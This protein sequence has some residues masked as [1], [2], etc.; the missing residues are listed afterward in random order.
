MAHDPD[1]PEKIDAAIESAAAHHRAGRLDEAEKGYRAAL[2]WE[3]KP[4]RA[5]H[6]LGALLLQRG[7]ADEALQWLQ[8]AVQAEPRAPWWTTYVKA[9][10][11]ADR[12]ADAEQVLNSRAEQSSA[13]SAIEVDLRQRW[14]YALMR[15]GHL[16]AAEAQ[17]LQVI[18]LAPQNP[19]AFA[20]LGFSELRQGRADDARQSLER[21][22]HIAPDNVNALINLGTALR[23]VGR[24]EE[25]EAHYRR[26]LALEPGNQ[27]ALL[28]LQTLRKA[29]TGAEDAVSDADALL[30]GDALAQV[31]RLDEALMAYLAA[32][33]ADRSA[34][35]LAKLAANLSAIGQRAEALKMLDE[36]VG[37]EPDA[38]EPRYGR[39]F[40]RL[41][42]GDFAGGWDDYEARW[43]VASFE[44]GGSAVQP[45][46]RGL[47]EVHT[48]PATIPGSHILLIAEQGVGDEIMFASMIPDLAAQAKSI[49]CLCEPRLVRLFSSSFENVTFARSAPRNTERRRLAM[50]GL[51]R[52]YRNKRS[53]FP[54]TPYLAPSDEVRE[55][56]AARLGRPEGLRIGLSW[57]GGLR[58]TRMRQRSLSLTQLTPVLDLPGCEYVSLQYG[59]AREEVAAA[60]AG[61]AS[62][63]Q[64]FPP[65][66]IDDFEELA[67]LIANLDVVVSVQTAVV[68]L[69]GALGIRCLTMVPHH[70]EW[71]YGAEGPSIPWYGSVRLFRQPAPGAWEPV[72]D[73]VRE[74]L[75]SRL[76]AY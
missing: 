63:I 74:A 15:D 32:A 62:P 40:V 20:D 67:G 16:A 68:H 47:I 56:W 48:D 57:R 52:L 69:S 10:V 72:I 35:A 21:A 58:Q 42:M 53:D 25:A 26:A 61:L 60:N 50:G 39:A 8:Q 33:K 71:R 2:I 70:A 38:P 59:D 41:A 1:A 55:R 12:F 4:P 31:G 44:A 14:G 37:L 17:F 29:D 6:N 46:L 66:E 75:T 49:L 24:A 23:R 76:G 27:A 34:G 30:R 65:D 54:G 64:L 51:G 22:L 9:L 19:H 73:A 28:N 36:A 18:A 3:P 7:Q 13:A 5:A 45:E 11:R 43:R